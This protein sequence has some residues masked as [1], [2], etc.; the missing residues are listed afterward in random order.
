MN[1]LHAEQFYLKD[2][3]A[4]GGDTRLGI[5][6]VAHRGGN[7]HFPFVADVHGLHGDDPAFDKVAQ[8]DG[9]RCATSA[10]VEHAAVDGAAGIVG[11]DDASR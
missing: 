6:A 10:A 11:G 1:L 7:I 9:Q 3:R 2:E 4:I 8:A 5:T